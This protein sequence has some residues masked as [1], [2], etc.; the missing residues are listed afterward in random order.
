MVNRQLIRAALLAAALVSAAGMAGA[1]QRPL[2]TEDPETVGEGRVLIEGGFDYGR[3][4]NFPLS[5][6]EGNL[7]RIPLIGVSLGVGK[8]A[9]I[10][11]D[12]GLR[13][14]LTI[15]D[16]RG[17]PFSSM[18]RSTG[19]TTSDF[20]DIVIGAKT[21][22]VPESA[23]FPSIGM[24][25]ATRLPNAS[26]E[27]GLGND[28]IDFQSTLLFGKTVQSVRVVGNIG[29]AFL[30]DPQRGESQNDVVVYGLSFA[31]AITT[32]AEVV[33]E[34]NGRWSTASGVAPPGTETRGQARFGAR[35]TH[36]SVRWDGAVIIG[37]TSID[38]GVGMAGGFTYVFNAFNVP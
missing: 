5:G 33:G 29:A 13:N 2:T 15:T 23:H 4:V 34:I 14:R 9:E 6:L 25:F 1:Q 38:P 22:L 28:T 31:R 16:R 19:A 27:S 24:R 17:A 32:A 10:Q 7:L 8:I 3:G 36:G 26:N 11:M 12:G 18:L 30:S 35:Y 37:L 20:E 21:R